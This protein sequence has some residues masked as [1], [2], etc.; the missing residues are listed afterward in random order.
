MYGHLVTSS[1]SLPY[2]HHINTRIIITAHTFFPAPSPPTHLTYFPNLAYYFTAPRLNASYMS[3]NPLP[4]PWMTITLSWSLTS[5]GF[6]ICICVPIC[7]HCPHLYLC[8]F[9]SFYNQFL[10]QIKNDH[11]C[12]NIPL[13]RQRRGFISLQSLELPLELVTILAHETWQK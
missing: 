5:P 6:H 9:H 8:T 2:Y 7:A 4:P 3:K 11:Q 10:W 1:T 13:D 12:F